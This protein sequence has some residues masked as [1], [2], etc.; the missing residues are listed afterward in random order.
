MLSVAAD[1]IATRIENLERESYGSEYME[2][3]QEARRVAQMHE[4]FDSLE[5]QKRI[6]LEE[7]LGKSNTEEENPF[8]AVV[9]NE[10]PCVS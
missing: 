3:M 2:R 6:S 10:K 5:S 8:F 1:E 4:M 9:L 7:F